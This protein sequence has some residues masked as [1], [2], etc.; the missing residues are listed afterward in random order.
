M[1]LALGQ[2]LGQPRERRQT[3]QPERFG[4]DFPGPQV[5]GLQREGA[6]LFLEPCPPHGVDRVSRLQHR[7]LRP[8]AAA[9]H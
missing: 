5:E 2:K 3:R 9:A 7:A 8:R 6:E 4:H 1:R